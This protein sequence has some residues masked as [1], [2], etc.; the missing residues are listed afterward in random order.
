MQGN[1][2]T[3]D[4]GENR[5]GQKDPS[6]NIVRVLLSQI[7]GGTEPW[8]MGHVTRVRQLSDMII[9]PPKKHTDLHKKRL[10]IMKNETRSIKI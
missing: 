7:L 8:V 1:A 10:C 9:P 2:K 4:S 5:S 3:R 6:R